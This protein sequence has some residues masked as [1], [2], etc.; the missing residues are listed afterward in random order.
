MPDQKRKEF[1]RL[2][3]KYLDGTATP[4]E[5]EALDKYFLLFRD[6]PK[7]SQLLSKDQLTGLEQRMESG[8]FNRIQQPVKVERL[9]PRIA[10]AASIIL[11]LSAGGYFLLHK[12]TPNQQTAQNQ[13]QDIAPGTNK[14][15]LTLSNGKRILLDSAH[16]GKIATQGNAQI[17]KNGN[18]QLVY[19]LQENQ[20]SANADNINTIEIPRGGKHHLTLSDGTG[21]WLNSASSLK[22]PSV[23][24]GKER[25]VELTGEAYFEVAH[26]GRMPF[27]VVSAGQTV[28]DIGTHFNINAYPDEPVLKTTLLEGSIKVSVN[29]QSAV[30]KPGQ[31]TDL[32]SNHRLQ[33]I[34]DADLEEAVAWKDNV[35]RFNNEDLSSIMRKISRWYDVEVE[36]QDGSV[37]S[38]QFGAITTRFANASKVLKMLER[39]NEVHFKIVE[40]S[41]G[42]KGKKIVVMK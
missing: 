36:Y 6:E 21:V 28:E 10:A 16:N 20:N 34:E 35:F 19:T 41:A 27:R 5:Q 31:Q 40:G 18:G 42:G 30:L 1:R 17:Q 22:F 32:N 39:T 4:E 8:L 29:G 23:F 24:K 33:V 2:V 26:N 37:K 14:A 15:V 9:W 25:K 3:D 12:Q 11:A 38:L 13:A 7:H